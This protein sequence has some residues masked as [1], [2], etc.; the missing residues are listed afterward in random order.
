VSGAGSRQKK[1]GGRSK[2]LD[3]S[4]ILKHLK[5]PP[6]RNKPGAVR[7][8][9]PDEVR[10]RVDMGGQSETSRRVSDEDKEIAIE[11]IK[12]NPETFRFMSSE[13]QG[14]IDAALAAVE[15]DGRLLQ[16][17]SEKL[18]MNRRVVLA[19]FENTSEAL[20]YAHET[21]RVFLRKSGVAIPWEEFTERL[22]SDEEDGQPHSTTPS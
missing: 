10:H 21:V 2:V 1:P 6:L 16:Y 14:D 19:A 15:R 13:L 20:E 11:I 9:D 3:T 17:A 4:G 18:R 7:S 5:T 8:V 12:N 22:K